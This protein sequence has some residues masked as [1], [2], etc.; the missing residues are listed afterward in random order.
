MIKRKISKLL[1][2]IDY[3][4][5]PGITDFFKSDSFSALMHFRHQKNGFFGR[6]NPISTYQIVCILQSSGFSVFSLNSFKNYIFTFQLPCFNLVPVCV[7]L[8]N[9]FVCLLSCFFLCSVLFQYRLD[10][11]IISRH[12]QGCNSS[13]YFRCSI[14]SVFE[15]QY[16]L[17]S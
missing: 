8:S 4:L 16:L 14:Q 5:N 7:D 10:S 17:L 6:S 13:S 12:M 15:S 11:S 1:P 9:F 2:S 3:I